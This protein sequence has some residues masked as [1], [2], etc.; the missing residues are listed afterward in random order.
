MG[1]RTCMCPRCGK[2]TARANGQT[3]VTCAN[4]GKRFDP[5]PGI[6][7]KAILKGSLLIL[8]L[9]VVLSAVAGLSSRMTRLWQ[10]GSVRHQKA[11][12]HEPEQ[13]LVMA[14]VPAPPAPGQ[15]LGGFIGASAD[16]VSHGVASPPN[17]PT[18]SA[19][20]LSD[21]PTMAGQPERIHGPGIAG[22]YGA[23]G[24][25]G[26]PDPMERAET[27]SNGAETAFDS[28]STDRPPPRP[29]P[30]LERLQPAFLEWVEQNYLNY[31]EVMAAKVPENMRSKILYTRVSR[32]AQEFAQVH[33]LG[34]PK[35]LKNVI[36]KGVVVNRNPEILYNNPGYEVPPEKLE[37]V[38]AVLEM[39][40][41]YEEMARQKN[42]KAWNDYLQAA[43]NNI[44][45][46][47]YLSQASQAALSRNAIEMQRMKE[48]ITNRH[49]YVP[50]G[51]P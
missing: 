50:S 10:E 47:A 9:L 25:S 12:P 15:P 24:A 41:T 19:T 32:Q 38:L 16:P 17:P 7:S 43:S 18:P 4:C 46:G 35:H 13:R 39:C 3:R 8:T 34:G 30:D 37:A 6:D 40:D 48:A 45:V 14:P 23:V 33:R 31:Q 29:D 1:I 44:K 5:E 26:P 22:R 21:P 11:K 36:L 42:E 49:H 20:P 51:F 2:L 28:T 27:V